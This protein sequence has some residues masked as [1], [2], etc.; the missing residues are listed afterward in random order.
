M[1]ITK[2]RIGMMIAII[3]ALLVGVAFTGVLTPSSA[4]GKTYTISPKSKPIDKQMMRYSFYNKYTRQYYT[5]RSYMERFEKKGGGTL[6]L[7]KG[8]YTITNTIFVPSNVTIKLKDGAVIKK[9][10]NT[11]L[12]KMKASRSLF[13]FIKPSKG[14][15]KKVYGKYNGEKNISII[16]KGNAVINMS[17]QKDS[18]CIEAGHNKG[19]TIKGITFKNCKGGHFM[20]LDASKNVTISDCK[21]LNIKD[22]KNV[23]EAINMDTPDK[24]TG[25]FTAAWSKFDCTANQNVTIER[26]VFK[27]MPRAIGTH[28]YSGGHPHKNI[29]ILDCKI[30]NVSSFGIGMMYWIGSEITGCTIKGKYKNGKNTFDG[31]LGYGLEKVDITGNHIENFRYPMLFKDYQERYAKIYNKIKDEEIEQFAQNTGKG[32]YNEIVLVKENNRGKDMAKIPIDIVD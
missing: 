25:G 30:E 9:G 3:M 27:N 19:I 23:R 16:G 31:I 13:H 8:T 29:K 4:A 12:S 18:N 7:K 6:V 20:E 10:T 5:I 24:K 1:S 11:H 22:S 2:K 21:F 15:K 32:L 14:Q 26:C 28:N 17:S